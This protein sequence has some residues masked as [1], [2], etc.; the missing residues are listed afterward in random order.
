MNTHAHSHTYMYAILTL[1]RWRDSHW[2]LSTTDGPKALSSHSHT[3]WITRDSEGVGVYACACL[4]LLKWSRMGSLREKKN[5][6]HKHFRHTRQLTHLSWKDSIM[7]S[8]QSVHAETPAEIG[9]TSQA[10]GKIRTLTGHHEMT[11]THKALCTPNDIKN[12]TLTR[13]S[14]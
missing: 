11:D 6:Y 9:W 14:S 2:T 4:C 8:V 7:S 5:I 10:V 1:W 3:R 13:S 12:R